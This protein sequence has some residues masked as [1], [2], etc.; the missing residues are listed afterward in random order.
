M[1]LFG[2]LLY[3]FSAL[4]YTPAEL[5]DAGKVELIFRKEDG[6]CIGARTPDEPIK[7]LTPRDRAA[8]K[9]IIQCEFLHREL[10]AHRR[11]PCLSL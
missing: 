11:K 4:D 6:H 3:R 10:L 5:P 1:S 9:L 2:E 7:I 8:S